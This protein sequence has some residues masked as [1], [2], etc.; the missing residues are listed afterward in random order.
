MDIWFLFQ[1]AINIVLGLGVVVLWAKM[2]RPPQDDPRLSRGLQLLQS[3]IAV[4]E[5]L[6]DRTDKQVEQLSQLVE[7]KTR[8]LQT[9]IFDA[10]KQLQ[11][12]DQSMHRSMEVAE[13]FQDKIPHTEI[14]ERQNTVKYVAAAQL[15]HKG[16]SVAEILE[17]VD[18]PREQ[19]EF[20]VKVNKDELMFDAEQLPP[21]A[22]T[23]ID[24][25]TEDE[26]EEEELEAMMTKETFSGLRPHQHVEDE[27]DEWGVAQQLDNF[28]LE[29]PEL[30]TLKKLGEEFRQACV[31]FDEKQHR[32]DEEER[33]IQEAPVRIAHGAQALGEK[34]FK[35]THRLHD[36]I[37]EKIPEGL[38]ER[39]GQKIGSTTER[40]SD[41]ISQTSEKLQDRIG[42]KISERL[43]G[44]MAEK[45]GRKVLDS[46]NDLLHNQPRAPQSQTPASPLVTGNSKFLPIQPESVADT[47]AEAQSAKPMG[48][49]KVLSPSRF[50]DNAKM[51][52]SNVPNNEIKKVMFPRI[53][54][55]D[56]LG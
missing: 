6:S 15:A 10:E 36:K 22:K 14:I 34:I 7:Q 43:Q 51:R 48:R 2:K 55:D 37:S 45:L 11:K 46:S 21:W 54:V 38:G 40:L 26:I 31:D 5:D 19:I 56:H 18:L 13:I 47:R 33:R 8:Q 35:E 30:S 17:K 3:K 41:R 25:I 1:V 32:F 24:R 23:Q 9:K 16:H 39:I 42:N 53:D 50:E 49:T 52:E 29:Q 28:E 20:I 4:L 12:V 27:T 44:S